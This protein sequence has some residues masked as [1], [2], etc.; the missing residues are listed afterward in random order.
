MFFKK[1]LYKVAITCLSIALI[2]V[3]NACTLSKDTTSSNYTTKNT[4]YCELKSFTGIYATGKVYL[5]WLVNTNAPNCYFVLEKSF[6][7][8]TFTVI[9]AIKGFPSPVPQGLLYSFTDCNLTHTSRIYRLRAI[10]PIKN[11]PQVLIYVGSKNLFKD[12][13]NAMITVENNNTVAKK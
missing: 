11:G 9:Q 12:L 2:L 7:G 4:S 8:I 1:K 5:N 3:F 6:D 10:Q 13:E